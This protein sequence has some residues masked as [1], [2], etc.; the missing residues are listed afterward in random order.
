MNDSTMPNR[1]DRTMEDLG[2]VVELGHVNVTVPDQRLATQYYIS[3]LGLTR[4]PYLMTGVDNMWA[5]VGRSQFHLPSRPPQVVRGVT[6]LVL[7]DLDALLARLARVQKDLSETKFSFRER[8][9]GVDTVCPW[10][11]R[12]RCHAPDPARFGSMRLGM[13]YV[14]FD[15]PPGTLDGIVRFYRE[16]LEGTA[17][18]A[19]D[20]AGRHAR[21]IVGD[22]NALIFREAEVDLPP[23]DGHHVQISLVDFPGRTSACS[24]AASSRRKAISTSTASKTSSTQRTAA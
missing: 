8:A 21:A 5:N 7:A 12:I 18:I 20:T 24:N 16:I 4:D 23:F 11:N 19:E 22:G 13:P 3:G 14:E 2:N 9:D 6:G 1:F 15:V 10:G 17:F